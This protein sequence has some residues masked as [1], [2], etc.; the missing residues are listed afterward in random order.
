MG[1]NSAFKALNIFYVFLDVK[2][3]VHAMKAYVGVELQLHLLSDLVL[4]RDE[5]LMLRSGRFIPRESV[6]GVH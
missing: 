1:F 3:S 2:V 5:W 6:P 4:D